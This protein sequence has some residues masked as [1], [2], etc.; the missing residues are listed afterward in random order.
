[1]A[2]NVRTVSYSLP[3]ELVDRLDAQAAGFGISRSSYL[4]ALLHSV[5][6]IPD[7]DRQIIADIFRNGQTHAA[8]RGE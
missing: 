1:M 3:P 7:T 2:R 5:F 8:G 4:T 6:S